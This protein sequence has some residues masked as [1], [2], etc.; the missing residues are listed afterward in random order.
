MQIVCP[1]CNTRYDVPDQRLAPGKRVR[2]ARCG[3][4]WTPVPP[5]VELLP[6][7]PPEPPLPPAEP[8]SAQQISS[9]QIFAPAPLTEP[10]PPKPPRA[11]RLLWIGWLT[12][13]AVLAALVLL[14]RAYRL[15]IERTW[16]PSVRLYDLF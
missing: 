2:C 12:T 9:Q 4:G 1:A 8:V 10:P 11:D 3:D 13:F 5:V 7:D 14:A 16:P 6:A 15:P